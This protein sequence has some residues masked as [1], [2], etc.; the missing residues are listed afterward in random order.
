M[1]APESAYARTQYPPQAADLRGGNAVSRNPP[2]APDHPRPPS[3][4]GGERFDLAA[5]CLRLFRSGSDTLEIA[6]TFDIPEARVSRLI[7]A[8]R[9]FERGLPAEFLQGDILKRIAPP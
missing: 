9:C 2:A 5:D 4:D 8:Q 7:W 3:L 1:L 6:K